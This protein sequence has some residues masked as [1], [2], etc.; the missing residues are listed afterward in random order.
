MFTLQTY[1]KKFKNTDLKNLN[2]VAFITYTCR[3]SQLC[4][5]LLLTIWR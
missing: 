3:L 2:T 5:L 4:A 1:G